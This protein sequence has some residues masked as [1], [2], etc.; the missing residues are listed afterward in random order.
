MYALSEKGVRLAQKM[1]VGPHI[2]V[3]IQLQKA[4]VGPTSGPTRRLSHFWLGGCEIVDRI[5]GVLVA[6]ANVHWRRVRGDMT[7]VDDTACV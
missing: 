7:T 4:E 5:A 3:K 2:S 6:R 1:Q